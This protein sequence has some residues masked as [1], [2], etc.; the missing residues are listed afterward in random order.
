MADDTSE[1]IHSDWVVYIILSSDQRLYTGIT[2]N[3]ARRWHQHNNTR[4]GA[5]FFRGR[6]PQRLLYLEKGFNRSSASRR[7]AEIKRLTRTDKLVLVE[8]QSNI[9]WHHQFE[10]CQSR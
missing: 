7:E 4:S 1:A 5:K 2:N 8:S 6:A 9:D 3:V 10:L